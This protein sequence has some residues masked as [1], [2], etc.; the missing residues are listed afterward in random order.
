MKLNVCCGG[1]YREGYINIDFSDTRSD[2]EP[3]KVDLKRDV[4]K[5]GLPYETCSIDEI[6]FSE[7]LEH[8]C[9]F[10]GLK[11]LKELFRVLKIGGKLDLTVPP[12]LQQMKIL[13]LQMSQAKNVTMTDFLKAHEKWSVWKYHDDLMGATREG[14]QGDSHL[15]LWTKEMLRP[16]LEHVGFTIESIDDNIHVTA[17]K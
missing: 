15:S 6:R 3:I 16:V 10:D 2:G 1:D 13:L 12:A 11:I 17:R 5:D 4:L 7:S 8:F 14:S 9:R